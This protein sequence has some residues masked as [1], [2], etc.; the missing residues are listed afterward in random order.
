MTDIMCVMSTNGNKCLR[1]CGCVPC[2]VCGCTGWVSHWLLL[3][4]PI[5]QECVDK[6][7]NGCTRVNERNNVVV[8]SLRKTISSWQWFNGNMNVATDRRKTVHEVNE[9]TSGEPYFMLTIADCH[10]G[11]YLEI[12][13]KWYHMKYTLRLKSINIKHSNVSC[14]F[15]ASESR[16]IAF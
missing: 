9:P 14:D 2:G 8:A 1:M 12:Y 10:R 7:W 16:T 5:G 15:D 13:L 3:C 11:D 6:M 4:N